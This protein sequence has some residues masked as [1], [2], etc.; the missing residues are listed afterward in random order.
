MR[1]FH[2]ERFGEGLRVGLVGGWLLMGLAGGCDRGVSR[3]EPPSVEASTAVRTYP[4]RGEVVRVDR[5]TGRVAIRHEEIPGYMPAMTMAFELAGDPVLEDLQVGDQIEARLRV[6]SNGTTLEQI[7]IT[8]LAEPKEATESAVELLGVGEPVPDFALTDQEGVGL[9]LSDLRGRAVVLTF[10]YTRC[11]LPDYCPLMDRRFA[12]LARGLRAAGLED[13]VR[14]I[15]VSFDPEHDRPEVLRRHARMV[16]A[17]GPLWLF[18]VAEH[19][20]LNKVAPKLGL[21]YGPSQGEWIHTL[22]TA[23]IDREGRLVSLHR[24]RDWTVGDV[25]RELRDAIE[26]PR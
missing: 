1:R 7:V 5:E 11:P 2:S 9:R 25:V 4:L 12:E 15:S 20:E 17:R 16:G 10:I 19:E 3:L 26:R 13:S 14:L 6:D 23:V 21:S 18:A 22:S 24:G 8:A